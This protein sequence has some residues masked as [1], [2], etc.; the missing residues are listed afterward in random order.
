MYESGSINT[1]MLQMIMAKLTMIMEFAKGKRVAS[2]DPRFDAIV[3]KCK[4]LLD[5]CQ[6]LIAPVMLTEI[7]HFQAAI[8]ELYQVLGEQEDFAIKGDK[9][10]GH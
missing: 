6:K 9:D 10:A 4:D 5:K 3:I 2:S 1:E 7:A 8:K